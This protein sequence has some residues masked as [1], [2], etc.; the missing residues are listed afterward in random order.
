MGMGLLSLLSPLLPYI[1]GFIAIVIGYFT[2]RQ[3]GVNAERKKQEVAQ[4]KV[5]AKV[6]VAVSKDSVV[7][8]KVEQKIEAIKESHNPEPTSG[9]QFKF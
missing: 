4:A 3:R 1:A 7:D 6:Q 8:Q 5:Q 9:D 2:I